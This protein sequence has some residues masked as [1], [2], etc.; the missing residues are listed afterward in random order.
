M[1]VGWLVT[2]LCR[3][4]CMMKWQIARENELFRTRSHYFLS[5]ALSNWIESCSKTSQV[6][7]SQPFIT[8]ALRTEFQWDAAA[9]G[10]WRSQFEPWRNFSATQQKVQM[11]D[12]WKQNTP[13]LERTLHSWKVALND[14]M[15]PLQIKPFSNT[16][17]Q[18]CHQILPLPEDRY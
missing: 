16:L 14:I 1:N 8:T 15:I 7:A 10:W 4:W 11:F 5:Y 2:W 13:W 3:S 18:K 12:L 9:D 6:I 17:G